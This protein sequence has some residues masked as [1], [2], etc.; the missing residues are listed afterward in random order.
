MR[1]LK[2]IQI[3]IAL[4]LLV[5][6]ACV[7]LF[8]NLLIKYTVCRKGFQLNDL[9]I[10][11]FTPIDLSIPIF[12]LTYGSIIFCLIIIVRKVQLLEWAIVGYLLITLFRILSIYH[13]PLAPPNNIIPLSDPVLEAS[14][15]QGQK[16]CIDL[17]FSGHISAMVLFALIVENKKIKIIIF[18][19]TCLVALMLVMQHVH[20]SIDVISAPVFSIISLYLSKKICGYFY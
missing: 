5:L 10:N 19:N 14:A 12:I 18:I 8:S 3:R 6:A 2:H 9:L 13:I 1:E 11:Y 15:Y 17:F 4:W 16:I 20:Y 7:S